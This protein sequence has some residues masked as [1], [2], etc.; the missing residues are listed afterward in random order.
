MFAP[1][2]APAAGPSAPPASMFDSVPG[3]EGTLAGGGTLITKQSTVMSQP[4]V[5]H[6]W[7]RSSHLTAMPLKY[8]NSVGV[9]RYYSKLHGC[10]D[11]SDNKYI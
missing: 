10:L 4:L 5:W 2:A 6:L 3:Y 9:F 11:S 1:P 8:H 7:L